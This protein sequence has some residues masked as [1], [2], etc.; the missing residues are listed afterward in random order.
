MLRSAVL[1]MVAICGLGATVRADDLGPL[2]SDCVPGSCPA[3]SSY[4]DPLNGYLP[5]P[6]TWNGHDQAFGAIVLGDFTVPVGG[7][8]ETEGRMAIGGDFLPA[9]GYSVGISGG[10][11]YVVGPP[12]NFD[13]LIVRGAATGT[14]SPFV[15]TVTTFGGN[16][17]TGLVRIGGSTSGI[18]FDMGVVS[19]NVGMTPADLG[20]DLDALFASLQLKSA[21]WA[22]LAATGT[23]RD[24][25]MIGNGF[26]LQGDNTSNPQVFNLGP[27]D[28]DVAPQELSF[29]QIPAG[30]T[31]LINVSG[32][33]PI[34][35]ASVI[36]AGTMTTPQLFTV[37]FNVPSATTLSIGA[38][39][40]GSL[41]VPSGGA[42]IAGSV[43]G[44][45]A[46]GGD[47]LFSG[48]GAEMHNYPFT[49]ELPDCGA[50]PTATSTATATATATGTA[51]DTATVTETAT[52]SATP[53]AT[54]TSSATASATPTAT[55]SASPTATSTASA[56]PTP[57]ST[58]TTTSTPT[59]SA[60][61]TVTGTATV[62]ATGSA[63]ATTT[64]TGTVTATRTASATA[65][66]TPTGS[67]TPTP[68]E[69]RPS[70]P[71]GLEPG[72]PEVP[73]DAQP[74]LDPAEQCIQVCQ[75]T[76]GMA[77]P[78]PPCSLPG[79]PLGTG[80]TNAGGMCIGPNGEPGIP[81][82]MPLA[83]GQ[84]VYV[85]DVCSGLTSA[86]RCANAGVGMPALGWT[87][88]AVGLAGLIA[89]AR[90]RMR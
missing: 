8:A 55:A 10:G 52:A 75:A 82:D 15:G 54:A 90:R 44:R 39:L 27:T 47:V 13:N 62:T 24:E 77:P 41:L 60:S 9:Q 6:T 66:T 4:P 7:A 26:V 51:T 35:N 36:R 63:T 23:L 42:S 20:I 17:V 48:A 43:N 58:P 14:N 34:I 11:T 87:G 1:A 49:G 12:M 72:E 67:Q 33:T 38:D 57:T 70:I 69:V 21:C 22:Q 74:G 56:T 76:P 28:L 32:T 88:L 78:T 81:L 19:S 45:V 40:N 79:D 68:T 64:A 25:V 3:L 61:P 71:G 18:T 53:S 84:C 37:L 31:V 85:A 16:T 29:R 73:C 2:L 80:G 46:V 86:I 89:L 5:V 50:T 30:A 65:S 83:P 59:A